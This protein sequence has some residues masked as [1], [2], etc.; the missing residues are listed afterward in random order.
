MLRIA[1]IMAALLVCGAVPD[2]RKERPS[3]RFMIKAEYRQDSLDYDNVEKRFV[4]ESA[5]LSF[6]ESSLS[7]THVNIGLKKK[8]NRFT[9]NLTIR[10]ISPYFDC[11]IG[12]FFANFGAGTLVGKKI[13]LSPDLFGR[14]LAVSRGTSFTPSSSGNPY[15]CF[16][17]I[18]AGIRYPSEHVTLSLHGYYSFRNRFVRN[19]RYHPDI[20]GSSLNSILIRTKKDYR[21]SEPVDIQDCGYALLLTAAQRVSLQSYFIYTFIRRSGARD[22]LWNFDTVTAPAGDKRFYGYGFYCQYRDDY[23]LIFLDLCFPHRVIATSAGSSKTV[24][25]Y[26]LVYSLAFRHQACS[27]SFTGKHTGRNFYSPYSSG[28]SCPETAWSVTLSMRPV[29]PFSMGCS[30]Y[31][32]KNRMPSGNDRYLRFIRREQLF[33]RYRVPRKGSFHVRLSDAAEG[34]KDGTRRYLQAAFSARLYILQSILLGCGGSIRLTGTGR[35]SGFASCGTGFALF[36]L[37]I[38]DLRY[39]YYFIAGSNPLYAATSRPADSI[40]R[41]MFIRSSSHS[42]AAKLLFRFRRCSF[43]AEYLH[44][45]SGS[46]IFQSRLEASG[47]CFFQ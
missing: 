8:E 44:R 29:K 32:E 17:G 21:Y 15:F 7:F 11:V 25:G 45:F 37:L 33:L 13:A 1:I 19:D 3:P 24:R 4:R 38:L 6:G 31:M 39:S 5:R 28:S 12:H 36:R 46:R 23:I 40:S 2:D 14:S 18:A 41:G 20:T 27:I 47:S 35:L 16:Q 30:F 34:T 9:G 26:G 22:L 43:S 10:G 42:V